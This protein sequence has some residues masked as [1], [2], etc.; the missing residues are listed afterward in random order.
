MC[1]PS[2]VRDT[3]T[4]LLISF[5]HAPFG[6]EN[7][8]AGLYL[9]SASI[10]KGY[11]VTLLLEGDGVYSGLKGQQDPMGNIGF[12]STEEQMVNILEM[13]GK[14]IALK[15]ALEL[16]GIEG[17]ALIDKIEVLE[18]EKAHSIMLENGVHI[19]QF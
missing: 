4:R 2:G 16:R 1:L 17:E 18:T 7:T 6:H 15:E 11:E 14:V 9:A 10:S 19:V 8:F 5:S 13:G 12:P 3:M